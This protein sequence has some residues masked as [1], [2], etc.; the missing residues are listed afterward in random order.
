MGS[1]HDHGSLK[2]SVFL[3]AGSQQCQRAEDVRD[4]R[5]IILFDVLYLLEVF[6]PLLSYSE[7]STKRGRTS[8]PRHSSMG[9]EWELFT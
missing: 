9:P 5:K 4:R 7:S 2:S 3:M 6:E 1:D 8:I